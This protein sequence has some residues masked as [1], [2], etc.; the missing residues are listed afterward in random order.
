[1]LWTIINISHIKDE[2]PVSA[3]QAAR[4]SKTYVVVGSNSF[5]GSHFVDA[6]LE[7]PS[8][9]V[10]GISRSPEKS[11]LYL[12]YK[13]HPS[14]RF[15]F[16]QVDLVRQADRLISLLDDLQPAY[17]I[18]TA[19]LTE[20][21]VSFDHPVEYF[22]TNC[23]G[24]VELCNHLRTRTY[25][26]C[27]IHISTDEVYGNC[28]GPVDES[29]PLKP[30]TPYAASKAA[31]DLY[32]ITLRENTDFPVI[33]IRPT[34]VYGAHQQL[35]KL[36]PRTL[37]QLSQGKQV[38]LHAQGLVVR[39]YIHVRDV[40]YGTLSA[41]DRGETGSTYHFSSDP[42]TIAESVR[43]ICKYLGCDF[44]ISVR[45][46]EDRS[47]QDLQYWLDSSRARHELGWHPR[48]TFEQGLKEVHSWVEDNWAEI[49]KE[50]QAYI[51]QA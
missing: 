41:I 15:E 28:S 45:K 17:I 21:S 36:I 48:V 14:P 32:L 12:P 1:M 6:L 37:I 27:Y 26:K 30:S 7:D 19:A 43:A 34:N 38:E 4:H 40:V 10:V 31:A 18:Y 35:Y 44:E 2:H 11:D 5:I 42:L 23:L 49:L 20:V 51:H 25:L 33:L 47:Q 22:Q 16:H 50:P 24:V 39:S 8:N 29:A 9:N 46:V 3:S 13:R